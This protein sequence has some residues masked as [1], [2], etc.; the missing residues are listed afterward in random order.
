[1]SAGAGSVQPSSRPPRLHLAPTARRTLTDALASHGPSCCRLD[2][3]WIDTNK[4][5]VR[6]P[7]PTYIDYVFTW[8]QGLLDDE[9]TFP[10]KTGPSQI[11]SRFVSTGPTLTLLSLT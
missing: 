5:Q 2:F 4:R 8:V 3:T 10:T 6:L 7:A 1:M 11:T 9:N